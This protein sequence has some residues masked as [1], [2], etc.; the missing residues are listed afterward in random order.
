MNKI[1][2]D[3]V[4]IVIAGKNKGERGTVLSVLGNTHLLVDGI[5]K[6]TKHMKP[7]PAKGVTGGIDSK[8]M[9]IDISNVAL[10]NPAT[11]RADR[12][13]IKILEDGRKVRFFKSN[14]EVLDA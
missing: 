9:P 12:I 3:D 11:Q 14:G 2:K 10:L 8:I 6:V 4:V 1:R 5:N 7:N 13:G